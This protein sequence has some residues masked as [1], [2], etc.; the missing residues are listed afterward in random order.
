MVK[1]KRIKEEL[2]KLNRAEYSNIKLREEEARCKLEN[3]Q[4]ELRREPLNTKMQLREQQSRGNYITI[5]KAYLSFLHQKAR[6]LWLKEGDQNSSFYHKAIQGRR[7]RNRIL[8]IMNTEGNRITDAEEVIRTFIKFYQEH[9]G[10]TMT[11][12]KKIK[13]RVMAVGNFLNEDQQRSLVREYSKED[14]KEIIVEIPNNKAPGVDGFTV[15]LFKD[16]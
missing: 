7:R 2:K 1:L 9:L 13:K 10:F 14:V 16:N 11:N 5:K 15:S 12:R 3:D 8:S 6:L 4:E